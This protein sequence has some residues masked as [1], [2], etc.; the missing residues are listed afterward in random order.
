MARPTPPTTPRAAVAA[1][2]T[3]WVRIRIDQRTTNWHVIRECGIAEAA[4]LAVAVHHID[5]A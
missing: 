3:P 4:M 1:V 2:P 5:E